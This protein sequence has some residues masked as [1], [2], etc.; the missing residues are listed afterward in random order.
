[1]VRQS[2][3]FFW[4]VPSTKAPASAFCAKNSR[5]VSPPASNG[6]TPSF[7]R[8]SLWHSP[9]FITPRSVTRSFSTWL[10]FP[11]WSIKHIF[12][13]FST[14]FGARFM[15]ERLPRGVLAFF[16]IM[17]TVDAGSAIE[18]SAPSIP[19]VGKKARAACGRG[20][21][22]ARADQWRAELGASTTARGGGGKIDETRGLAAAALGFV[23]RF[24]TRHMGPAS[25]YIWANTRRAKS[26]RN[27]FQEFR[28]SYEKKRRG[29]ARRT[30]LV[31]LYRTITPPS[32][33]DTRGLA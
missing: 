32:L 6:R 11:P 1:M 12:P 19:P 30:A 10:L 22:D 9:F 8:V 18:G 16:R 7:L 17:F 13:S 28:S 14:S 20:N 31:P 3:R 2:G 23:G 26:C 21:D 4:C 27:R 29:S 5:L 24:R 15:S 25:G 33:R